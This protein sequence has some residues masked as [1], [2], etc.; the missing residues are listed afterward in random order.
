MRLRRSQKIWSSKKDK[1]TVDFVSYMRWNCYNAITSN[2]L[3]SAI[4]S[5]IKSLSDN[6]IFLSRIKKVNISKKMTWKI[7]TQVIKH[8]N[9]CNSSWID[10]TYLSTRKI[11]KMLRKCNFWNCLMPPRRKLSRFWSVGFYHK[12]Q[13]SFRSG[14]VSLSRHM[15]LK[16]ML[17][18]GK[19]KLSSI[20]CNSQ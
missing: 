13:I 17:L 2:D 7:N 12:T 19:V 15:I 20:F 9:T 16:F 18:N 10:Y 6:H 14:W 4:L 3:K 1:N 5:Q 11:I 8:K